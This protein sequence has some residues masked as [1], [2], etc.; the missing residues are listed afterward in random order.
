MRARPILAAAVALA[1]IILA[2]GQQPIPQRGACQQGT[3]YRPAAFAFVVARAALL[4]LL[5]GDCYV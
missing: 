3:G 5:M 4:R 1:L 2:A